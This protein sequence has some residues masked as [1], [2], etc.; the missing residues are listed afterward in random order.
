MTP[1]EIMAKIPDRSTGEMPRE[2][3]E[4]IAESFQDIF[5]KK[6][7]VE[8]T[9]YIPEE[10]PRKFLWVKHK[11]YSGQNPTSASGSNTGALWKKFWKKILWDSREK[12]QKKS[13]GIQ[14]CWKNLMEESR[15]ELFKAWEN[16]GR[17]SRRNSKKNTKECG[18]KKYDRNLVRNRGRQSKRY[19]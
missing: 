15:K 7:L 18:V 6:N 10:I 2:K 8:I 17:I 1:V 14:E 16:A 9:G 12:F 4:G 5:W 3:T 11:K 13:V 19:F